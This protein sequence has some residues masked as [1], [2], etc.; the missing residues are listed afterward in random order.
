MSDAMTH[1]GYTAKVQYS[2]EDDRFI[3]LIAGIRVIVGFQGDSVTG[4]K[5]AFRGAVDHSW[6]WQ[7]IVVRHR[8][9]RFP[10]A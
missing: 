5:R 4:L 6:R 10:G 2:E 1:K 3:G 8:R 7:R 9:N